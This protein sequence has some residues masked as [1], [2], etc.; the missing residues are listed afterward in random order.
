LGT[1]TTPH[2]IETLASKE[3]LE[4]WKEIAAYLNRSERTVRR[5]EEKEGLPVHRL[6]HDK[7]GSVYGFTWELDAWRESRRQLVEA[8]APETERTRADP[9]RIGGQWRAAA[10][11]IT[12][13]G[14]AAGLWFFT[15][16]VP[17]PPPRNPE[18]VRLVQLANFA[19]N[20]G[21][22]QIETGIR[23]YQDAIRLDP[24]YALAWSGL[25]SAHLVRVW[26]AEVPVQ[27]GE[28]LARKEATE[29]MRL[30]PTL[31]NPWRVFAAA[32]HFL[33]W[34]HTRADAEFRKAR[35]LNPNDPAAYSWY[36]DYL[37]DLRRFD[38]ARDFYKR[39]QTASPRWLE[40][41]AFVGNTYL[42]SGNP[43]LAIVEYERVLKSEPNFGLAI[44]YLGRA[45][46]AKG[47]YE[48]GIV[49][50]R[51]SN[52]VMG[53]VPLSVGD[54]GYSLGKAGQRGEA[55]ALRADLIARRTR[56]FYP[57]FPIGLI[58]LGLGNEE[59]ALNWI[60][61]AADERNVGFYLPSVDPSYDSVRAHPRFRAVMKRINLDSVD[62]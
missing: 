39:A 19:L 43:D 1:S 42:F 36:A 54:L 17:A 13:V 30:D 2:K 28:A 21:R 61:Q 27:E 37:V 31:G 51:K 20:A 62:R 24:E 6:A 3:R 11:L 18:A 16:P 57:A 48:Q 15:R 32:S 7:R 14:I 4:S 56:G 33:D 58:E 60:E 53:E 55:E 38:E 5:W 23:Y 10:I 29:A 8:E 9:A 49:Q 46:I 26:F 59:S 25:A 47:D 50:L 45:L 41:I 44:H 40:P 34:E 12:L 35:E 52:E 22:T